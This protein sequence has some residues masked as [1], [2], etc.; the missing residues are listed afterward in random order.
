[1]RDHVSKYWKEYIVA[2]FLV[3]I[4]AIFTY[5]DLGQLLRPFTGNVIGVSTATTLMTYSYLF[6]IIVGPLVLIGMASYTH[7]HSSVEH[8]NARDIHTLRH[9]S[10]DHEL[11]NFPHNHF[12]D[13]SKIYRPDTLL[14]PSMKTNFAA[15]VSATSAVSSRE[16]Y[17]DT[18]SLLCHPHHMDHLVLR[19]NIKNRLLQGHTYSDIVQALEDHNW[20]KEKINRAYK[21]IKMT[22][23]EAEIMLGSYITRAMV[24][25]NDVNSIRQ[26]LVSK[27]WQTNIVDKVINNIV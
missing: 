8:H 7:F 15:S 20:D 27:G 13:D 23:L 21:E 19:Q 14:R 9:S 25:G 24:A 11:H 3:G 10:R 16:T 2:I 22:P 6:L 18:A 17:K 12:V 26:E 5:V 4:A 1:M